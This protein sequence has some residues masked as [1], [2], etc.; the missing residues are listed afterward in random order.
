MGLFSSRRINTENGM[1][2]ERIYDGV[3]YD[4]QPEKF[5]VVCVSSDHFNNE[6]GFVDG[7]Y[8]QYPVTAELYQ[9]LK[10][11]DKVRV[12]YDMTGSNKKPISVELLNEK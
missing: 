12:T 9:K 4:A 1:V 11:R 5:I 3:K 2:T 7:L 10:F 8:L 6:D